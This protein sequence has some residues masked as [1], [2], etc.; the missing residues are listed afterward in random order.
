[1]AFQS[2][3]EF[4][5]N[6]KAAYAALMAATKAAGRLPSDLSFHRTLDETLDAQLARTSATALRLANALWTPVHTPPARNLASIDDVAMQQPQQADGWTAAPGF[7]RVVDGIDTLLER[8]DVG[9]DEVLRRPAHGQRQQTVASAPVKMADARGVRVVHH[10]K[11]VA[12]PQL[13]FDDAVDNSAA[14]F[15]WRIREKPH[16]LVPL[17]HVAAAGGAAPEGPMGAHLASLGV[18][19]E[20]PHPY[21]HEIANQPVARQLY[22]ERAALEPL[23][24]DA[25]PFAF[26][27]QPEA[28]ARMMEHLQGAGEV[29]VDLEHHSYR[30]YQGFTCLVQVS[31]RTHDFVV[32]ALALRSHLHV[33]NAV[34]ADPA[35]VKVLHGAESDVVW[36]QRDFGV[37][38]V[39]LFDTYHA[40]HVLNMAHHSLAHLLRTYCGFEADKKHQLA[41][42]RIRPLPQEMLDYARSDTH[43]L[44][45]VYDCMRNELVARGRRLVG[46]DVG[47]PGGACFGQ[48]SL[49]GEQTVVQAAQDGV[50]AVVRRS[51]QTALRRYAKEAYDADHGGGANGWAAV[52]R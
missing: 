29:A 33:L 39:G 50:D 31:S 1:M 4:G 25:T 17:E 15:A 47:T 46:R 23:A 13:A 21:A 14:P 40:S 51:R 37:Y 34:T 49:G 19:Y 32:D 5:S 30:S 41:D 3:A 52:L 8:I 18:G 35:V 12:R 16:A 44:L 28:L 7:S 22:E 2:G 11:N 9:L 48:L 6:V 27:D 38:L 20:L 45:Y 43:F 10:G 26:V 36:L 24:W 42:W